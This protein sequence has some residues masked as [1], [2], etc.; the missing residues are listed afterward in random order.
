MLWK[1][2]KKERWAM[3]TLLLR[4]STAESGGALLP[5]DHALPY[6][7]E[8]NRKHAPLAFFGVGLVCAALVGA[9]TLTIIS[10]NPQSP[11]ETV[12][13]AEVAA[14]AADQSTEG[15]VL[16]WK[17]PLPLMAAEKRRGISK[18]SPH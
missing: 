16:W 9:V 4:L 18:K 3:Q 17:L 5:V 1:R 12:T 8:S 15:R 13:Y 14:P 6:R 11:R 2:S 7:V 10:L